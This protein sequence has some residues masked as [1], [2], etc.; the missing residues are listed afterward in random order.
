MLSSCGR[1]LLNPE[2]REPIAW[3]VGEATSADWSEVIEKALQI[4][5]GGLLHHHL[6]AAGVAPPSEFREAYHWI[7]P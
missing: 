5:A 3:A 2:M 7:A 6:T 1:F 4:G